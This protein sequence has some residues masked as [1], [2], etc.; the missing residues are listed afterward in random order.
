MAAELGDDV[1]L[2]SPVRTINWAE[3]A[4]GAPPA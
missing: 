1:V 4:G 3:D 2:D